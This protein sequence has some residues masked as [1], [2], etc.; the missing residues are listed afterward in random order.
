MQQIYTIIFTNKNKKAG[1]QTLAFSISI[2]I[3]EHKRTAF[4]TIHTSVIFQTCYLAVSS[5]HTTADT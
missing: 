5:E 3:A 1:V 4:T 2:T